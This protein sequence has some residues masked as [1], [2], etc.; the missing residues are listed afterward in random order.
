MKKVLG[1]MVSALCDVA[2]AGEANPRRLDLIDG[3]E[4]AAKH[5]GAALALVSRLKDYL[6][7]NEGGPMG[8]DML[9]A[10]V[11]DALGSFLVEADKRG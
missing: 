3:F 4:R 1:R 2:R 9:L 11:K 10:N 5:G 6:D 7:R 8:A